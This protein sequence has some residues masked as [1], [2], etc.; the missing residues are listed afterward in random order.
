M[1][2]YFYFLKHIAYICLLLCACFFNAKYFLIGGAQ[3]PQVMA[4]LNLLWLIV[5][6]LFDEKSLEITIIGPENQ[7]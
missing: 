4:I 7:K 1:K 5:F 2:T 3:E 6:R